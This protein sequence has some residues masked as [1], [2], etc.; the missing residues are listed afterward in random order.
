MLSRQQR[1]LAKRLAERERRRHPDL[2]HQIERSL[3]EQIA[4]HRNIPE[5]EAAPHSNR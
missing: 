1:R 5:H 4:A 2:V 3:L